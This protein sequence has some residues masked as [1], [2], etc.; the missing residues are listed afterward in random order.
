MK[1]IAKNKNKNK[2]RN[3]K[4]PNTKQHLKF[5]KNPFFFILLGIFSLL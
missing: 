1:N 3:T 4:H 2:T 5:D